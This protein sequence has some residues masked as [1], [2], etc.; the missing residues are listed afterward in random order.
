MPG[1]D[2]FGWLP[3][4]VRAPSERLDG[5]RDELVAKLRA[6]N[7][8][9]HERFGRPPHDRLGVDL[10]SERLAWS[11][12]GKTPLAAR[13]T[14]IGTFAPRARTWGWG[15][16]NPHAP[17]S[18]RRASSLLVDAIADRDAWELSTP[19]FAT[20][21]LT[22]WAIAAFVWDRAKGDAVVCVPDSEGLV[23]LLVR[24]SAGSSGSESADSKP[25]ANVPDAA[26][27]GSPPQPG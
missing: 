13:A 6:S 21:E 23:F 24:E 5:E 11:V 18:V 17:E 7:D 27:G 9:F 16:T 8:A 4:L 25:G 2:R 12:A 3:G 26:P 14:L 10:A 22:A 15:G 20:D 19:V 1:V